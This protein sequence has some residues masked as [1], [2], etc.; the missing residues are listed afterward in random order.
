MKKSPPSSS[1]WPVLFFIHGGFLQF[2]WANKPIEGI[3]PLLQ[4]TSFN[5]IIV[6]PAY[7]I[8]AF[9]FLA[10][11][12]LQDEAKKD[13]ESAG[14]MGFWDQRMALEW[15]AKNIGLFGGDCQKI[16]VAGYSAG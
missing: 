2:G 13:G 8:N 11:K 16:T 7:R 9:G 3:G 4:E 14:N 15:T 12:E 6:A 10:S 1:G 5:A